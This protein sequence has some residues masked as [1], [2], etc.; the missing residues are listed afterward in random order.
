M[1]LEC[2]KDSFKRTFSTIVD[3]VETNKKGEYEVILQD[4][5]LFPEGGGQ[6]SDSGNING[7]PLIDVKKIKGTTIHTLPEPLTVGQCVTV[8]VNWL[9]RFDHMQ[10]HSGQH[11]L[12]AAAETIFGTKTT[13]WSLGEEISFVEL[14]TPKF[15]DDKVLELE[16]YINEKIIEG[17]DV[18]V[19]CYDSSDPELLQIKSRL[20]VPNG[21]NGLIRVVTIEGIDANTCC[22]THVNNLFQL[23][24]AKLLYTEKGKK[25]K[26]NLYFIFGGRLVKYLSTCVERERK[27]TTF[28]KCNPKSHI[29]MIEKIQKQLKTA[30][31]KALL[32]SR[33]L[34]ILEAKQFKALDPKPTYFSLHKQEVDAD[35]LMLFVNEVN[36]KDTVFFLTA[37][38]AKG[39]GQVFFTGPTQLI[40]K[41]GSNLCDILEG[42]GN[43]K[44]GRFQAKVSKLGKRDQ[45]EELIKREMNLL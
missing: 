22:G 8:E 20:D 29:D 10:Q 1:I 24:A 25:N 33:E 32:V 42:K 27:A 40:D 18:S 26:T 34:A 12:S 19:K 23:Q 6:P 7:I 17:I 16:N 5:I 35:F 14:D 38:D 4:T 31:K 44:N 41:I 45:A 13:S 37:G 43:G 21:E 11:L 2:Q 3:S 15:E 28:L 36:D 30:N 9:R 39:C